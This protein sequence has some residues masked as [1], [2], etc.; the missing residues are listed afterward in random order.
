MTDRFREAVSLPF[1]G[2]RVD[3]DHRL[4]IPLSGGYGMGRSFDKGFDYL[5]LSKGNRLEVW[6]SGRLHRS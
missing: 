2:N 1:G 3:A 4:P 6:Q 5:P